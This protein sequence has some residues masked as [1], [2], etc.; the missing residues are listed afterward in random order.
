ML[1]RGQLEEDQT[2]ALERIN[3]YILHFEINSSANI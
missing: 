2:L 1:E 3:D